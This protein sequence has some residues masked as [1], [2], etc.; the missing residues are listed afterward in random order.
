MV[1]SVSKY[2]VL[3][4]LFLLPCE[5]SFA[6]MPSLFVGTLRAEHLRFPLRVKVAQQILEDLPDKIRWLDFVN[7]PWM[8]TPTVPDLNKG[9]KK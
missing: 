6:E 3:L 8:Y 2:P 7:G 5:Q 1:S 9:K 4:L